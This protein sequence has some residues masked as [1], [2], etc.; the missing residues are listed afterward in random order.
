MIK[1]LPR[2][3]FYSNILG[4]WVVSNYTDVLNVF[5]NDKV[6]IPIDSYKPMF[7]KLNL[8]ADAIKIMN[9]TFLLST[10]RIST[11]LPPIH[12]KLRE[13]VQK[14]F[15]SERIQLFEKNIKD[16]AINKLIKYSADQHIDLVSDYTKFLSLESVLTFLGLPNYDF[17]FIK[18]LHDEVTKLFVQKL[19]REEQIHAAIKFNELKIYLKDVVIN[20]SHNLS[21]DVISDI[22]IKLQNQE[23]DI[24]YNEIIQLLCDII[25]AGFD[26]TYKAM[27]WTIYWFLINRDIFFKLIYNNKLKLKKY[28]AESLRLNLAQMGLIRTVAV[29]TYIDETFIPKGSILYLIHT[30][31]N[32]DPT[33]FPMPNRLKIERNNLNKQLT[34][35]Y[36]IHYCLGAQLAKTEIEIA[37]DCLIKYFP[38]IALADNNSVIL[39]DKGT[40]IT[41][42]RLYVKLQ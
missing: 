14:S 28:V 27:N 37:L 25:S 33:V 36:G 38:K 6:F 30:H 29:D 4:M 31:A 40:M 10:P 23:I 20:K 1:D 22:L 21:D 7:D 16:I 26:T 2:K 5:K 42:D 9:Q 8:C 11:S 18:S 19:S 34:F 35:G 24:T 32:R 15:S 13:I 39:A 41:V 12:T 3:I 17:E